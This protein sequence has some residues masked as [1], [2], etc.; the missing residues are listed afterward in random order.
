ME[1]KPTDTGPRPWL[2]IGALTFGCI[3]AVVMLALYA[4]Q[5]DVRDSKVE[6]AE[7][8]A[9]AVQHLQ[10]AATNGDVAGELLAAYVAQGDEALIPQIQTHA[11]DGVAGLTAALG[12][13]GS[14]S[15]SELASGGAA[16]QGGAG[17][18]IAL[19]QAG[20]VEGALATLEE[21]RPQFEAFGLALE[22]TTNGE[23]NQAAALQND[24]D[25]ADTTASWLLITALAIGVATTG[26]LLFVLGR[27]L[28]RRRVPESPTPA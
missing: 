25:N 18:V 11:T 20:D 27:S 17:Q 26:G 2:T 28:L 14:D 22:E 12:A 7:G 16:L 4:W 1:N 3:A 23:L 9:A 8:H 5:I 13:S 15:I 21:M 6:E 10:D 24:A 19:R